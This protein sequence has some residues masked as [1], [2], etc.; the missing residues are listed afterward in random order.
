MVIIIVGFLVLVLVPRPE[1][2]KPSPAQQG[3]ASSTSGGVSYATIDNLIAVDAPFKNATVSSPLVVS[4]TA[5][6]MWYFEASAPIELRD[7][8]GN[9]I[10]QSHVDAQGDWMTED[11]VPFKVT[12]TFPKQPAGSTGTLV[13]HNDNP[14]GD[15]E[16]QKELIVPVKF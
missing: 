11:F 4:G 10:A 2:A 13:L 3:T 14:S 12:L 6:G 7:A 8:N 15:P 16:R 1:P 5:R 9:V